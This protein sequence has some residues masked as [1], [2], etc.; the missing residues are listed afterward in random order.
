MND[1]EQTI[2]TI[3][4]QSRGIVCT[5]PFEYIPRQLKIEFI[6]FVVLWFNAF[7]VKTGIL[8]TYSPREL[9]VRWRLDYN[10]HCQVLPGLYCEVHDKPVPSNT[11]TAWSHECVA[12]GPTR[13]L[14]GSVKFY[15]PT[16]GCILKRC[17]FTPMPT[18]DRII[19]RVNQ[20]GLREKQGQTFWFLNRSKE[21]YKWTDTVTEDGLEFQGL[22][23]EEAPFPNVSAKLPEVI[24]KEDEEEDYQV[25]TNKPGPVFHS[26][27]QR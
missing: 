10:K 27:T 6:Y 26:S 5:L 2:C 3:K 16:M 7:L 25:A 19:K 8:S 24:L 22:L 11:L 21:A 15:C 9:L 20:I 4:E 1:V 18:P 12:C 17:S 23:E 14:Q 13:N